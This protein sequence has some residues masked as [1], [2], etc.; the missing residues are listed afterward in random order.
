MNAAPQSGIRDDRRIEARSFRRALRLVGWG[1]LGIRKSGAH[2]DDMARI[3]PGHLLL[4]GMTGFLA[5]I[6]GL[7]V[8]A[9]W[10]AAAG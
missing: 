2:H 4:A 9:R 10:M 1:L 3:G 7:I 6:G 5:L 8:L